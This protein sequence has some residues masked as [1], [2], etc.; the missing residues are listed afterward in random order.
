MSLPVIAEILAGSPAE[1]AGLI[2]GDEIVAIDGE[3][4]SDVIR[5][6]FLVDEADPI[7]SIH[8]GGLEL[9]VQVMKG[10]GES[11]GADVDAS[12][13]DRVRTCDNHCEFCF[14]YQL[15]KGMRRSLYLKDDDYRLSFLHGNFTTLT[16]FTEA[17]LERVVSERLSPLYVSIHATDPDV[18]SRILRNPRGGYSLR[19]LRAL[20]DFGIEVHG[21]VVVCPG[22]ND[23]DVLDDTLLGVL[24][25][26]PELS[27]VAVV[28]LGVSSYNTEA[29]MRPHTQNEAKK[30]LEIVEAWQKRFLETVGHRL[31]Y[32][33]DEYYLLAGEQF[34][35]AETYG[36]FAMHEDGI[37]MARSFE[38][39]FSGL[40][41]SAV[42]TPSGFF[43]WVD[44]APAEGYREVRTAVGANRGGE[45]SSELSART[46]ELISVAIKPRPNAPIAILTGE[47]GARVLRPLIDS[48]ERND[49]RIL[50]VANNFFGGNI[51]VSGL[52][53]GE[54]VRQVLE[55]EPHGH[56]YLLP[57]VCLN[58]GRFL[59]GLQPSDLPK[60]VEVIPTNGVALRSA[61]ETRGS[62]HQFSE[63]LAP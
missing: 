27:S 33:A 57:D 30:V 25:Q 58:N 35:A 31:V 24:D 45:I 13:F 50:E 42:G 14:I 17:D 3:I 26:F 51:K 60:H 53:V 19:W 48:L 49:V 44:G 38:T 37:G 61:L 5:W 62:T 56:Q 63:E 36:E 52:M 54:D 4:P 8:R 55:R 15:P 41:T 47:Y 20:L 2:P 34:P 39:E 22:V 18:R 10:A 46:D 40:V 12:I 59:D 16:R 28:P 23:G 9:E 11:L 6:H 21:Q 32:A 1:S 29:L 7:F 43:Q